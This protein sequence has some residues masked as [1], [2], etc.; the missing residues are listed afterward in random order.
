M[1]R[2]T[3]QHLIHGRSIL[4]AI[5]GFTAVAGPASVGFLHSPPGRAQSRAGNQQPSFEVT[6]VK[7]SPAPTGGPSANYRRSGGPGTQ[8]PSRFASGK[9]VLAALIAKAYSPRFYRVLA[10]AWTAAAT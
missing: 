7:P 4:L 6:S 8:D 1:S 5:A 10:A 9:F 2:R 3:A